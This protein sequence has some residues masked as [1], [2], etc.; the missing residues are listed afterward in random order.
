MSE[1]YEKTLADIAR[2]YTDSHYSS[3]TLLENLGLD[4]SAVRESIK[5]KTRRSLS[6]F[7]RYYRLKQAQKLLREGSRNISEVAYDSGFS[8]LSYFSKSFK[9]E[10]GYSPNTSLNKLKFVRKGQSVLMGLIQLRKKPATLLSGVLLVAITLMGIPQWLGSINSPQK[11][12][13][14]MLA[15][16][17]DINEVSLKT[18][19]TNDTLS[20]NEEMQHYDISWRL[21]DRYDWV[22]IHKISDSTFLFPLKLTHLIQIRLSEVGKESFQFK[23]R[24]SSLK[25]LA[26]NLDVLQDE[27]GIYFP[28]MKLN[29]PNA[30]FLKSYETLNIKP[31]YIDKYEVSNK[32]FKEFVDDNGYYKKEFW[33]EKIHYKGRLIRFEEVKDLFVDNSG[34]PSPRYWFRGKYEAG[35]ELYPVSGISWYEATAY[36]KYRGKSLPSLGQWFYAFNRNHPNDALKNANITS[37]SHTISR[38]E[39]TAKNFY[40]IHDLAGNVREWVKNPVLDKNQ[41]GILGGSF[42]DNSYMAFD[43]FAQ[44]AWN[45]SIY[46]GVR[47]VK[48]VDLDSTGMIFYKKG[49][50]RNF[51]KNAATTEREWQLIKS[52]YSY[53]KSQRSFEQK[54]TFTKVH[55]R[56]YYRK[57]IDILDKDGTVI[58]MH[59][60]SYD[61]TKKADKALVYFPGSNALF[62]D[63]LRF[64]YFF[65]TLLKNGVDIICPEYLS[66][67][68]RKDEIKTDIGDLSLAYRDHSITWVKETRYA[69]DYLEQAGISPHFI[70]VSWGGQMG[71]NILAIEPRFKTGVLV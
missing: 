5:K 16:Y 22:P 67:Y 19:K 17:A 6:N 70:G 35:K 36:A 48:N 3:L 14:S 33:P 71:V 53:E 42:A 44:N 9:D 15:A 60:L 69:V 18:L 68:S 24:M 46:N 12:Q 4:K 10:F 41:R 51:Y 13:R 11:T 20:I 38:L 28:A 62:E 8:S 25:K 54:T 2:H 57:R 31:F 58:P 39:S 21:N 27:T 52:L 34:Y 66:T 55:D 1:I 45:R 64:Y 59:H 50:S 37:G 30:N 63:G 61:P 40:G 29:L 65:D 43:F 32:E 56:A 23:S 26:I 49:V 7:I 47:L